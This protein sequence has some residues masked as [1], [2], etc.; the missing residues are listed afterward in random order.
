MNVFIDQDMPPYIGGYGD[1]E[2]ALGGS[3]QVG[4]AG[5]HETHGSAESPLAS[6]MRQAAPFEIDGNPDGSDKDLIDGVNSVQPS[7]SC[8]PAKW[9]VRRDTDFVPFE[10]GFNSGISTLIYSSQVSTV[11]DLLLYYDVSVPP[12]CTG[13]KIRLLQT[14]AIAGWKNGVFQY[15]EPLAKNLTILV[16]KTGY[17]TTTDFDFRTD[18]NQV[19]ITG[20][21]G[22][23][24]GAGYLASVLNNGF[25]YAI[26]NN[27]EPGTSI[28]FDVYVELDFGTPKRVYFPPIGECFSY[29]L[30]GTPGKKP[31][32]QSPDLASKPIPQSGY[33]IFKLR[34]T[35]LPVANGSG[36]SITPESGAAL[37]ITVG[38]NL[39]ELLQTSHVTFAPLKNPDGSNMTIT[40]PANARDSGD[41]AAFIPVLAGNELVYQCS[42]Q[43]IFE[44]WANWQPIFFNTQYGTGQYPYDPEYGFNAPNPSVFTTALSFFNRF[45]VTKA[46]YPIGATAVQ[47]PLFRELYDDLMVLLGQV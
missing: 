4:I 14:G 30:D 9:L 34:A 10:L 24:G 36:I 1:E 15:G 2:T 27:N 44:A 16:K 41:V 37:T 20:A 11:G 40:I 22:S 33:C 29:C 35:R 31:L 45:N 47:F 26:Q 19:N 28:A 5:N 21:A 38:Q 42:E 32:L 23:D 7:I 25:T 3:I 46:G 17:P 6:T 13:V 8:R 39:N 12:N 18:N 43:V